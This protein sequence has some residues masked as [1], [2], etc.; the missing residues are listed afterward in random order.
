MV[1]IPYNEQE[2]VWQVAVPSPD[3]KILKSQEPG[4]PKIK[5][6]KDYISKVL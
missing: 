2:K 3:G 4:L 6:Y 1:E 5:R